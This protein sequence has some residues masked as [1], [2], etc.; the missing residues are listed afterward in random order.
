MSVLV[1]PSKSEK[2][3]STKDRMV[4]AAAD[5]L[6]RRGLAGTSFTEVLDASGA[7]RGAIYHHFPG[8]KVE[9][10]EAV[11]RRTGA[12]AR[13]AFETLPPSTSAAGVVDAF[14]DAVR[15]VVLDSADGASCAVAAVA[16]ESTA[17]SALQAASSEALHSWRDALTQRLT[18]AGQQPATAST[19]AALLIALLEGSHVLCR[20]DRSIEPFDQAAQ[21][22]RLLAAGT[23]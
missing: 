18:D 9:L 10:A 1:Q 11:V 4:E 21:A 5:S 20:A 14:L 23:S 19:M 3:T 7:A 8:G 6:R 16:N 13:A 15:P 17:G 22:L 2:Q 12:G